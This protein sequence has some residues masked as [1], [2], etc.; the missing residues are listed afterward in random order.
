VEFLTKQHM[1][2]IL[3]CKAAHVNTKSL[4]RSRKVSLIQKLHKL[5][6]LSDIQSCC[7]AFPGEPG[8]AGSRSFLPLPVTKKIFWISGT[9]FL[10]DIPF[11]LVKCQCHST[12]E[13]STREDNPV[14]STFDYYGR[15]VAAFML[16]L[17]CRY[18]NQV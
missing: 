2:P 10:V 15:R 6:L 18:L 4:Q 13:H 8:P 16:A 3:Y 11:L 7:L 12:K 1:H 9:G 17:Q 14:A 5:W